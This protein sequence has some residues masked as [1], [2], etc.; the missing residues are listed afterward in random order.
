MRRTDGKREKG[1]IVRIAKKRKGIEATD[2]LIGDEE[3]KK[4]KGMETQRVDLLP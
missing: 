4:R 1:K 3:Q 2:A